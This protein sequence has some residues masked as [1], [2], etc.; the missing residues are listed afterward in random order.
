MDESTRATLAGIL[1]DLREFAE[2]DDG[3]DKFPDHQYLTESIE[4]RIGV[5]LGETTTEGP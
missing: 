4:E 3:T 5:L 2:S 1:A